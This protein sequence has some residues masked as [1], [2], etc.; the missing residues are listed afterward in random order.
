M[1]K[2]L[3]LTTYRLSSIFL[4]YHF[5][6]ENTHT[7][8]DSYAFADIKYEYQPKHGVT[9]KQRAILEA[10]FLYVDKRYFWATKDTNLCIEKILSGKNVSYLGR[11]Y[12]SK[13]IL[14]EQCYTGKR[15][16]WMF[17]LLA[18]IILFKNLI[19]GRT[20]GL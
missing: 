10:H 5:N 15:Y 19:T 1:T 2:E 11:Y 3:L 8:I 14:R 18:R 13:Q 17:Y 7:V 6:G 12:I 16:R 4:Y 20:I 9:R